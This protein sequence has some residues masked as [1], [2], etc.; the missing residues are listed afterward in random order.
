[1]KQNDLPI[2]FILQLEID[3]FMED[4]ELYQNDDG[5]NLGQDVNISDPSDETEISGDDWM[6][7]DGAGL[8]VIDESSDVTV[9][10]DQ[11]HDW[12]NLV[13]IYDDCVNFDMVVA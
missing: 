3:S 9:Q 10:W 6:D 8:Q 13:Q 12:S 5:N 11:N 1:M 4:R 7:V 2:S